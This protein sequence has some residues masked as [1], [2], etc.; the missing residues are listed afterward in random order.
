MITLS[1]IAQS[2]ER[3]AQ[4]HNSL[5]DVVADLE[6]EL[7]AVRRK[8]LTA[9]RKNTDRT[10]QAHNELQN[11]LVA[12][13][14]LFQDPKTVVFAGIKVGWRKRIGSIAWDD[15]AQVVRLIR[16]KLPE[17][18][19][20]LVHTEERP[21]KKA[22]KELSVSDLRKIGCQ[23]EETGDEPVIKPTDSEVDRV[24]AAL[25]KDAM[26]DSADAAA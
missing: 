21:V 3:Y 24:V 7:Q 1:E 6:H 14:D 4:A 16:S 23:V 10:A 8:Y 12:G 18:A 13:R 15:D 26:D 17:L 9:V 11:L 5:R 25:L 22:L 19:D 20:V 2:T